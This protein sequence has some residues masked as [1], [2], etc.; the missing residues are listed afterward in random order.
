MD[1]RERTL[2]SFGAAWG[3]ST[4]SG[5][6]AS[7]PPTSVSCYQLATVVVLQA[8]GTTRLAFWRKGKSR[9]MG[10]LASCRSAAP[11]GLHC[12]AA[13]VETPLSTPLRELMQGP[14]GNLGYRRPVQRGGSFSST[15][16]EC[17]SATSIYNAAQSCLGLR[18]CIQRDALLI[19]PHRN[20]LI[21]T[22]LVEPLPYDAAKTLEVERESPRSESITKQSL[23][24]YDS[25]RL[26]L[27]TSRTQPPRSWKDYVDT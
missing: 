7:S 23:S 3:A 20:E 2:S 22:G 14:F 13:P 12:R 10:F 18:P 24:R 6:A 11:A 26:E 15:K 8:L 1:T 9:T 21:C 4:V 27:K 25:S 5:L 17:R 16:E 19:Y